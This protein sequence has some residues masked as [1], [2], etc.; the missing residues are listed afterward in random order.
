VNLTQ[1]SVKIS[2]SEIFIKQSSG[3]LHIIQKYNEKKAAINAA[4]YKLIN[5][6]TKPL[7]F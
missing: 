3:Y 6:A 2:A 4:F 7:L 1:K 5:E